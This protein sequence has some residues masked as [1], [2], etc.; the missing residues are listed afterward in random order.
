MI[1]ADDVTAPSRRHLTLSPDDN[2][3]TVLDDRVAALRLDGGQRVDPDIPFGH[4]VALVAIPTGHP[5]VKYGVTIGVAT[6]DIAA[7]A[8]VHVHNCR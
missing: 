5:V 1:H 6:T 7:G 3:T 2:V 8:H 4:K